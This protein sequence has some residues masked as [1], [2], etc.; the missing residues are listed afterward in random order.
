MK[1]IKYHPRLVSFHFAREEKYQAN[2]MMKKNAKKRA[3]QNMVA[4]KRKAK[5]KIQRARGSNFSISP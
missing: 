2:P 3:S 4:A 1:L 5:E